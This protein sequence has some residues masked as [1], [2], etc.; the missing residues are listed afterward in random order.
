MPINVYLWDEARLMGWPHPWREE[1]APF[2]H[3][4]DGPLYRAIEAGEP[5]ELIKHI[6]PYG[7]TVFNGV[8]MPTVVA[9]FER[10]EKYVEDSSE[11]RALAAVLRLARMC[12]AEVHT[13]LVFMG[14]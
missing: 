5:L 4:F 12:E 2:A 8:Q 3:D 6:D 13:Y 9:E 1:H 7:N 10:L 11:K 14:D